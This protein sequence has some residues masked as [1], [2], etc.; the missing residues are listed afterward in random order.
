MLLGFHAGAVWSERTA[1]LQ[2]GDTVLFY[3]DGVTDTPGR[4]GRLGESGLQEIVSGAP[5]GPEDLLQALDR[6]LADFRV[7]EPA[8]DLAVLAAQLLPTAARRARGP[9]PAASVALN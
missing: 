9:A 1:T 2:S 3:T 8:D 4:Q 7:G 5:H 6:E